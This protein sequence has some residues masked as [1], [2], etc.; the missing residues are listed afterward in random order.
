[1]G[2]DRTEI[3]EGRGRKKKLYE[4]NLDWIEEEAKADPYSA[5]SRPLAKKY[6]VSQGCMLAALHEFKFE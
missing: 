6:E 1:M 4:E 5:S 3:K 2:I